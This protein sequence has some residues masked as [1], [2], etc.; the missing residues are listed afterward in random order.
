MDAD[1]GDEHVEPCRAV[2]PL[3]IQLV[4]FPVHR[5]YVGGSWSVPYP[6]LWMV[7]AGTLQPH[8]DVFYTQKFLSPN[9]VL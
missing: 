3:C 2:R 8:K 4:I 5:T 6:V 7:T 9:L 1:V